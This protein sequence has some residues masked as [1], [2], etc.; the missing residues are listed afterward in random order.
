MWLLVALQPAWM[1]I[2]GAM[3]LRMHVKLISGALTTNEAI[4]Y[5]KYPYLTHPT[6]GDF[7]V[8]NYTCPTPPFVLW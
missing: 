4:N 7:H 2:Y 1:G 3:L 8:R 5:A 6:T